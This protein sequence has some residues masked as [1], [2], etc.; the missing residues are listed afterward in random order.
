VLT[1][2]VRDEMAIS[3]EFGVIDVIVV[4]IFPPQLSKF[5]VDK[6]II[7]NKSPETKNLTFQ[8]AFILIFLFFILR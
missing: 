8:Y 3:V 7:P 2:R 1:G 6:N 5:K 4:A